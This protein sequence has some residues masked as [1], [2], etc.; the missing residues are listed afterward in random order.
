M[1]KGPKPIPSAMRLIWSLTVVGLLAGC[2]VQNEPEPSTSTT[3]SLPAGDTS[4]HALIARSNYTQVSD[5][6]LIERGVR[7][8]GFDITASDS[9]GITTSPRNG[10]QVSA[11]PLGQSWQLNIQFV[12]SE[13]QYTGTRD[14]VQARADALA[15]QLDPERADLVSRFETET[16]L[17]ASGSYWEP[18]IASG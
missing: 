11:R 5:R 10:T 14:E 3:P 9:D 17:A 7:A 13:I 15:E 12:G 2:T 16:G 1:F 4:L 8:M 6:S 18:V